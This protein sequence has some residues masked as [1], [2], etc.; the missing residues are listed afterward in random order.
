MHVSQFKKRKKL[1]PVAE[2][3]ILL[4]YEAISKGYWIL[5]K[6]DGAVQVSKDVKFLEAETLEN[7]RMRE[8]QTD[9]MVWMSLGVLANSV[10]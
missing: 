10:V 2:E 5:R 7:L 4:G 6:S 8:R 9:E 1:D 3:G